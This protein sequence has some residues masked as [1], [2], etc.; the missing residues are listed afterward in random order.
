MISAWIKAFRY[1]F[2]TKE[3]QK[4]P[5]FL[6]DRFGFF[7]LHVRPLLLS[8]HDVLSIHNVVWV[9]LNVNT[10]RPWSRTLYLVL[11]QSQPA[12][13]LIQL[14]LTPLHTRGVCCLPA[15]RGR[16][17]IGVLD[18]L[19]VGTLSSASSR[20]GCRVHFNRITWSHAFVVRRNPFLFISLID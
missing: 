8:C 18:S 4:L 6:P 7:P 11:Q 5:N 9:K 1:D 3:T 20:L 15:Q 16:G 10:K 12:W 13:L 2:C 19:L 17:H 14:P